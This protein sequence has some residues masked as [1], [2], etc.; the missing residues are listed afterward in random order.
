M[1]FNPR[2]VVE[3]AVNI[4]R[5]GKAFYDDMVKKFEDPKI[6]DVF[7]YLGDEEVK[8]EELFTTF[9]E[10]LEN[11]TPYETYNDDY[12]AYMKALSKEHVFTDSDK[13]K[14]KVEKIETPLDAIELAL[15]FEKDSVIYFTA[16]KDYVFED[17]NGVIDQLAKEE[18][19]H[20]NKLLS[21]KYDISGSF[22]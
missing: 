13:I 3:I 12:S 2:E 1:N 22:E 5:N 21:L 7:K 15:N 19:K 10:N 9:L 6:K 11:Y 17:K 8:H 16:M 4:E 20:I 14:K 18:M